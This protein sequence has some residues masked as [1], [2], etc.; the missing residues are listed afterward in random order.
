MSIP[1]A[2]HSTASF[3]ER[4]RTAGIE[5]GDSEQVR[6]NKSLLMLTTGLVS[7][8][9]ML[10][11]VIYWA[12]GPQL[13]S[14]LPF[15]FQLLLAGNMLLY[16][17]TRNFDFFRITQ[18]ALFL[19]MPFVVQW[20]IG[21]FITASGIVL[22]GLLAPI[23]AILFFGVR[24]SVAWFFAWVFMIALSGMFDYMLAD[25]TS[26]TYLVV[27]IRTSVVFFALNFVAVA[28]IIYLLLRYSIQ[29]KLK[30]QDKFDEAHRQLAIEQ[31]RAERLLLNILPEPIATRLKHS[32]QTIADGF[33]DVTVMFA[34][35][36]NFTQVAANMAPNQVFA[37]L[38]R[39]FSAFDDLADQHGLEKIKTIG[40]AY[41][42]AGGLNE[43][44]ADYTAAIADMAMA[45]RDLLQRDFAVN[46]AHLEIRIGIGTGPVVAGVVG[47]K[48]FIYD[49]WGDT[50]NIASRITAEGVPGMIQC[51][52]ITYHRLKETFDFHEPQTIYLKGKG[53]MT[54]YRLIGRTQSGA[55][56]AP[57]ESADQF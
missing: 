26:G 20:T 32:N 1:A 36:V 49:L 54:V 42:V 29:E 33:A 46:A 40:D 47:K 24:E 9:S 34:D 38:N 39:I 35:I 53:N 2:P 45:M 12:L 5:P 8:A 10:W 50:V 37:M 28:T 16:I 19:F 43:G 4:L 27:P 17:K 31:E 13:S 56:A 7:V 21:S 14:T 22:W 48:K 15:A 6:L 55:A 18:I 23:G 57:A 44:T 52:T 11:L 25:S 30:I 3:L 41:M 51:D